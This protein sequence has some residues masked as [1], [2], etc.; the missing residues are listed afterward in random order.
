MESSR[1]RHIPKEAELT[2][3][4][5]GMEGCDGDKGFTRCSRRQ[6]HDKD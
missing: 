4:V 1:N 3:R 2:V 5:D 6:P